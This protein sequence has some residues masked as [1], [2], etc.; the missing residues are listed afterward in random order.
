[1]K[2]LRDLGLNGT[3]VVYRKLEQDVAGFWQ[4]MQS[5]SQRR[6]GHADPMFMLR[7]AAKMVG[8]WPSG[9]P[10]SLAPDGDNPSLGEAKY[11]LYVKID[12]AGRGCPFGAH[13]R[14]SNPR[15]QLL[16]AAPP[17][18]L[19]MTARHRILRRGKPFGPPL[20]DL[21]VLD[22]ITDAQSLRAILD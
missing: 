21:C 19:N 4:F 12:P 1:L 8:R 22:R 15:D 13:I 6:L 20:F 2:G 10:L 16:P 17:E 18:S 9:A 14:R 11:F 7:L 3:F 5:E